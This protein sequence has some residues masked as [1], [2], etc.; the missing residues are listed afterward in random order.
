M[1]LA[2]ASI[3]PWLRKSVKMEKAHKPAPNWRI[4]HRNFIRKTKKH[5]LEPGAVNFSAGWLGQGHTVGFRISPIEINLTFKQSERFPLSPSLNLRTQPNWGSKEWMKNSQDL[6][7]L[8]NLTLSLIHPGLFKMGLDMLRKMRGLAD[9]EKIARDWQSVYSGIA[10]ICNRLTPSHRD[11]KGRPE[12]YDVLVSYSGPG[13]RPMLSIKDLGM[14]LT[15]SSGTVVGVCGT[16]FEHQATSWGL[17][18]RVCY[19]HFMRESV[20]KRLG[21]PPAGWATRDEYLLVD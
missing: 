19:A 12:W 9:T 8:M 20:R 17:G 18:D 1:H 16:V 13:T 14:H 7:I 2:T 4:N 3:S 15:Y 10:V 6:E 5:K 21:V 11:S